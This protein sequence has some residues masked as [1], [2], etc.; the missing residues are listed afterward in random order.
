MSRPRTKR[1]IVRM[2]CELDR[3][4]GRLTECPGNECSFWVDSHCVLAG[5]RADWD[6]NPSLALMLQ[7]VRGQLEPFRPDQTLIPPGLRD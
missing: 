6:A 1:M 5:L 3:A 7:H 4:L 2:V